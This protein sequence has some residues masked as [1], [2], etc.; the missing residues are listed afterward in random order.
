VGTAADTEA[1]L[2]VGTAADTEATLQVGFEQVLAGFLFEGFGAVQ[3]TALEASPEKIP[4]MV[5][6]VDLS[7]HQN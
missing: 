1:T 5:L 7:D 2:E 6:E 4:E 3:V